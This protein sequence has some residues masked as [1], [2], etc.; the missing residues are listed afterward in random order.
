MIQEIWNIQWCKY[1]L[2]I[3]EKIVKFANLPW[4]RDWTPL[5]WQWSIKIQYWACFIGLGNIDKSVATLAEI[6]GS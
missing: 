1:S 6:F 4:S 2:D 5:P 3:G